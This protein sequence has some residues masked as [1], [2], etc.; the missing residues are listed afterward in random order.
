MFKFNFNLEEDDIDADVVTHDGNADSEDIAGASATTVKDSCEI[1]LADLVM[2]STRSKVLCLL[3][4]VS[5]QIDQLPSVISFSPLSIPLHDGSSYTLARRDLYDARC[6]VIAQDSNGG[7]A[8][9]EGQG[10]LDFLEAPSDLVSGV[11][12]GGLK[13]W[14]CSLDLAGYVH[15]LLTQSPSSQRLGR[16]LEVS[17]SSLSI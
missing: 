4:R 11:Y 17:G 6:Q 13:T 14:E 1:Q 12:E 5:L 9:P 2:Y 15:D 10:E 8:V 3:M 7:D 16:I